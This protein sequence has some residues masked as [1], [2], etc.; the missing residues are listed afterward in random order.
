VA[1]L[2]EVSDILLKLGKA[3]ARLTVRWTEADWAS[4]CQAYYGGLR[5]FPVQPLKVAA[6]HWAATEKWFP[7]LSELRQTVFGLCE[8]EEGAPTPESAWREAKTLVRCRLFRDDG[9]VLTIRDVQAGDCSHPLVWEAIQTIGVRA[10]RVSD[11][12]AADRAHFWRVY[13]ALRGRAR[14]DTHM[15]PAVQRAVRAL[16][17][18]QT[19]RADSVAEQLAEGMRF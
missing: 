18:G 2:E 13:E 19:D 7:S 15:L 6:M 9:G 10:L 1:T 4:T 5:E 17:D 11:N 14:E 16:A 8:R 3:Y 12:E